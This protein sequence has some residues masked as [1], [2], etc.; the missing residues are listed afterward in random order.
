MLLPAEWVPTQEEEVVVVVD[1][2][3]DDNDDTDDGDVISVDDKT[4]CD[5]AV[6]NMRSKGCMTY[7]NKTMLPRKRKPLSKKQRRTRLRIF[8]DDKMYTR[9]WC[10]CK[11]SRI[12]AKID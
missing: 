11:A 3:N 8:G 4:A 12:P 2:D 6:R 5:D 7:C 10:S 9:E 1:D